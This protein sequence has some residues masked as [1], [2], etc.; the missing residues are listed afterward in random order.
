[1]ADKSR[2]IG[3]LYR[4]DTMFAYVTVSTYPACAFAKSHPTT[5][6]TS[7]VPQYVPVT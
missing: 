3:T 5:L 1:M 7:S 4:I 2:Y 6:V